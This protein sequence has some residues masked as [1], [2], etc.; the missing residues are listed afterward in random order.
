MGY[1][2]QNKEKKGG[3]KLT[4]EEQRSLQYLKNIKEQELK[5]ISKLVYTH[6]QTVALTHSLELGNFLFCSHTLS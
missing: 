6:P 4:L 2:K 3:T 1:Q 5:S